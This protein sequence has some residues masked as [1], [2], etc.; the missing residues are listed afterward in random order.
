MIMTA[1]SIR[2]PWSWLIANGYKDPENRS[3]GT[4]FRGQF[5]IHAGKGMTRGEW[6][7][8]DYFLRNSPGLNSLQIPLPSY[9][10]LERGGIIGAATLVSCVS[11]S[12][13]AWYMGQRAFILENQRPLPFFPCKGA[14]SFF[15]VTVPDDYLAH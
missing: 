4:K 6:S 11:G 1:L 5:L 9:S 10:S 8:V 3:W 7:D 13:S 14:L 2:Q 12:D 15:K